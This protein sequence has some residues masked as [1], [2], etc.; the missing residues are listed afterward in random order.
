MSRCAWIIKNGNQCSS[1]TKNEYCK[2]HIKWGNLFKKIKDDEKW[3]YD[4]NEVHNKSMFIGSN[5][6]VTKSCKNKLDYEKKRNAKRNTEE[7]KKYKKEMSKKNKY[8]QTYRDKKRSENEKEFLDHNAEIA[9]E[10]RKNNPDKYNKIQERRKSSLIE[11]IGYYKDRAQKC[12]INW[13][14]DDEYA[15][16]LF[17]QN[18]YYCDCNPP[19][20]KLNGIDR[21]LNNYG[22]FIGNIVS[23]CKICNMM[24][25]DLTF[26]IFLKRCYHIYEYTKSNNL[27]YSDIFQSRNT[28][29]TF[30]ELKRSAIQR[31]KKVNIT[32]KEFNELINNKKCYL[33]GNTFENIGIDRI[34]SS[35]NYNIDNC[36]SCCSSCNYLKNEFNLDDILDKITK[37]SQRISENTILLN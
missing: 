8:Y 29:L 28:K 9:K 16:K 7:R 23:C 11:K 14:I 20:N 5:G 21:V 12:N 6:K 10:W 32:I 2:T 30:W 15:K 3:C 13:D 26:D 19:K 4:C 22:Y 35:I 36:K 18:C 37:I 25:K 24:K 17:T 1:N 31:K 34:D 27:L 33:C